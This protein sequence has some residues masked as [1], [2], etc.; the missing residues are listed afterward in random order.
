MVAVA[1]TTS[2]TSAT[3]AAAARQGAPLENVRAGRQL[4]R[5]GDRGAAVREL[6]R[7]LNQHGAHLAV[8]GDFGPRTEAAVRGF[9]RSHGLEVD[10]IVGPRTANKLVASGNRQPVDT[11]ERL[12]ETSQGI[13]KAER[14]LARL[15]YDPGAVDGVYD[16]D[17]ARAVRGFKL[18]Q[19]ELPDKAGSHFGAPMKKVL[20]REVN[21]LQHDPYHARV[22]K[23][24]NQHR[25]LDAL[26]EQRAAR[27]NADGSQGFGEGATG[28]H[29]TNVQHHLRA[30]GFDPKHTNGVFDERTAG[31]LKAFQRKSGLPETGRVDRATWQELE[32]A[33]LYA[34]G[35]ATP[36]QTVGE[37]SAAVKHTES[38]LRELGFK[39]GQ[40]DG[41]FDAATEKAVKRFQAKHH[42]T[43]NGEVGPKTLQAL[44]RAVAAR[45]KAR[46]A[47]A[48]MSAREKYQFYAEIVRAHGGKVCPGG[49][50]TVLGIRGLSRGHQ[51]HGLSSAARYDDTF[52][53]LKNGKAY[54]FHGATHPGQSWSS[55]SP[56]VTGDGVGDVGCIKPGN[57]YVRP[58]GPHAGAASFWV[59][60]TGGSGYLPGW[61]D[62]NHDGRYSR[63][64]RRASERRSDRLSGVLFHQ[65]NAYA[66]S[67]I[68]CQ[69]LSPAEFRRFIAAVGGS[70]ASF[71]YTLVSAV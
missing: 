17:T 69:T 9:Q 7:L 33:N 41:V 60:T 30:A 15:G 64:E 62:T 49:K 25:R 16:R 26:T 32:Q 3:R 19:K 22:T 5:R 56:D 40:V 27:I 44:E 65:G 39:P 10:G 58:N 31:A 21:A 1:Q 61:R 6:Q 43:A 70:Q 8:D 13:L 63:A 55:M 47:P 2:S 36:R 67:S 20:N 12:G 57:Y 35:K 42:L 23:N 52:V 45:G 18:D 46:L 14:R 51:A 38:A 28:R 48:A 66:P 59:N 11:F 4:L 50:A 24:R 37:R 71:T 68:G 54:E 29:V 34:S 53:V